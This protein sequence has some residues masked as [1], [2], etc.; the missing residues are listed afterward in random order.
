MSHMILPKLNAKDFQGYKIRKLKVFKPVITPYL[1]PYGPYK[2]HF[3]TK[4][5]TIFFNTFIQ[6]KLW[7]YPF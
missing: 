7:V 6:G 1:G 2:Y 4:I 3:V 5:W